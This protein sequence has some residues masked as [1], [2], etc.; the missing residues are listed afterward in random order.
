MSLS[1][2]LSVALSGLQTSSSVAQLISGNISNTQTP[3]YTDKTANLS[4]ISYGPSMGGVQVS[5][6]SRANDSVLAATL[7]SATSSASYLNT[8]NGYMGQVQS[9]L[10]SSSNPP[11]L[12]DNLTKFQS[13]WM[14][15]ATSPNS[16]TVQQTVISAAQNLSST[17]STIGTQLSSLQTQTQSDLG[18]S[19]QQLNTDLSQI[20]SLNGQIGTALSSGQPAVD[21]QDQRDTLVN[22]VAGLVGVQTMPRPNGTVALYTPGGVLLLDG[23]PQTFSVSGSSVLSSTGVDVTSQLT[24]GKIQAQTDFLS[25]TNT[26]GNG[27]GVVTKLQSQLQNFA[28]M[29]VSTAVG[30]FSNTYSGTTNAAQ[31]LFTASAAGNGLPDLSTFTVNANILNGSLAVNSSSATAVGNTFTSTGMAVNAATNTLSNTFSATG[32]TISNQT[33]GGIATAILSGTQQAASAIKS[34]SATATTQQSYYQQSLSNETAV[35]TDTELVNLTNW[36]NAYAAS[37]HVIT[38][39]DNMF[40]ILE[41]VI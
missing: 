1:G 2:A 35:N 3:G 32:L 8:Q 27:V 15:F 28:N 41:N 26:S 29:F 7:N 5:G 11:A 10:G 24:G 25:T 18:S 22:D 36:Q 17:V 37:A 9:I 4:S 34:S 31:G 30:G 20:Q 6:Y 16:T 14:Q 12:T 33:Y 23:A 40:K 39:I 19:V 13:A 21:L 38:T